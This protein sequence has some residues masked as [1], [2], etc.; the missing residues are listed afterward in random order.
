MQ[1]GRP[2]SYSEE[3]A[4]FICEGISRGESLRSIC[5]SEAI[6][7]KATVLSWLVQR[8]DFYTKYARARL[9]QAE[10]MDERIL[11]TAER[12]IAG[13]IE[14]HAAKVAI[15]A[16]QWR[17]SKLAP[18]V[19]GDATLLKHADADG[20]ALHVEV[21]RVSPRKQQTI[22]VTPQPAAALP[23]AP[24]QGDGVPGGI[25]STDE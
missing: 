18:K 11:E 14:P 16:Y 6:P 15:G 2:S 24:D 20:N 22:D 7:T 23:A 1:A 8:P 9:A 10:V 25:A 3:T 4:N 5:D 13:E 12:C 17:A 21:T 19:Y